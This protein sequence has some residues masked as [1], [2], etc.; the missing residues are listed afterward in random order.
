[1]LKYMRKW[2]ILLKKIR[3]KTFNTEVSI[4]T[5][6]RMLALEGV[7]GTG[8]SLY[9]CLSGDMPLKWVSK[10]AAWYNDDPLLSATTG[11]NMG[12]I[13]K[14]SKICLKIGPISSI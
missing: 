7:P 6:L 9:K 11:I 10:S 3:L 8:G 4:Q 14:I 12:H 13:F 2:D 1:M 5:V